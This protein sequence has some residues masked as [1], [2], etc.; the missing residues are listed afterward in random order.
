[1][2]QYRLK[3]VDV[4]LRGGSFILSGVP[5]ELRQ[6][7]PG[8][9]ETKQGPYSPATPASALAVL[10][11]I[12]DHAGAQGILQPHI[13]AKQALQ[14]P[15][16]DL[17]L[18]PSGRKLRPHQAQAVKAIRHLGF[19][20]LLADD[21][22]LGKSFVSLYSWWISPRAK[23]QLLILCP[24]YIKRKWAQE[25]R[26]AFE[27]ETKQPLLIDGDRAQRANQ[28]AQLADAQIAIINYD[29]LP[30]ITEGQMELLQQFSQGGTTIFDESHY[31]KNRLSQRTKACMKLQPDQ[32]MLLTG[33]PIQNDHTDLFSQLQFLA[34]HW[35][36]YWEFE[37]RYCQMGEMRLGD[38]KVKKIVGAKR[39]SELNQIVN[40]WQ[41]ARKIGDVE[42]LPPKIEDTI[43]LTMD[44]STRKIYD[45][46]KRWWIYE[47]AD[48]PDE[49][50]VFTPRAKSALEAALRMEQICQS[51]VGGAPESM[52]EMLRRERSR[53]EITTVKGK[54]DSFVFPKGAKIT[55]L[56]ETI[57]DLLLK[58][59]RVVVW[60][61]YNTPLL[62]LQT[63]L[64]DKAIPLYGGMSN[65]AKMS[66]IEEFQ[67]GYGK[68]FLAQVKMGTGFDLYSA[69]HQIFF[70]RDWSPALNR[71]AAA[72]LHRIGQTGTVYVLTPIIS[73]GIEAY[74]NERLAAKAETAEDALRDISMGDLRRAM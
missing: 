11:L 48:I 21:M 32:V 20:V 74:I 63:V 70:G 4:A 3:P 72:R 33:T 57:H 22:G 69:Q 65:Q 59:H 41:V 16:G 44:E 31:L 10:G 58:D 40:C 24:A 17:P 62:Y 51:F 23:Q 14:T 54:S 18:A 68:V 6:R 25:I 52:V 29:L 13:Q 37:G 53:Q 19:R 28:F 73:D 60:F 5:K 46:M 12:P 64:G 56:L 55:W 9:K 8:Y 43:E 45:A 47:F 42:N 34:K 66:A 26:Q 2:A 50:R 35:R 7:I 39:M 38:R 36:S 15:T 67:E 1:M 61:K 30:W 71:Q 49:A 27:D